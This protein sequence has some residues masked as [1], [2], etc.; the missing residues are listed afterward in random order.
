MLL[1]VIII[2]YSSIHVFHCSIVAGF[3]YG[4]V[5]SLVTGMRVPSV[6]S[7]GVI[8]ALVNVGIYKVIT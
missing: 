4:V 3:G 6:M 8:C 2:S 1:L 5:L 7:V